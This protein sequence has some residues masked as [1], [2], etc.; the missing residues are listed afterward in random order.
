MKKLKFL[1][2]T[3]CSIITFQSFSQDEKLTIPLSKPGTV[4][5]LN[6]NLVNGSI[7]VKGAD[8]NEVTVV[9][10]VKADNYTKEH[11]RED[12]MRRISTNKGFEVTAEEQDNSVSVRSHNPNQKLVLE[13]TVPKNFN[14]K[15]RTVNSGDVSATNVNGNLEL[16][17]VNGSISMK[18]VSGS[19]I[20]STVNGNITGNFRS[21]DISSPMAFTTLNGNVDITFPASLKANVKVQSERGEMYSDFEINLDKT[22]PPMQKSTENGLHK[23]KKSG[24]TMG[25]I[26]SGGAEITMKTMNGDILIRKAK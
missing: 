25:K 18:D 12:G 9:T 17:N 20:T 13:V 22:V 26:G 1:T 7:H 5:M 16:G 23:I 14:L 2:I 21:T 3:L 19:A 6:V 8:V 24:W 4:G 10:K 15:V 11:V